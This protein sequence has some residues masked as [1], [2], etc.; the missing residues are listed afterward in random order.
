VLTVDQA[1]AFYDRMGAW[2]DWQRFYEDP[3]LQR[4]LQAAKFQAAHSIIEFG[5]G[6]GRFALQILSEI[7]PAD[8]R[9]LGV[10]L[11]STMAA[12]ARARLCSYSDRAEVRLS[13]GNVTV[14]EPDGRFDRYVSNYVLDLLSREST[15][16]LLSEAHRLLEPGGAMPGQS[17]LWEFSVSEGGL[18][19]LEPHSRRPAGAGWRMPTGRIAGFRLVTGLASRVPRRGFLLR[20]EFRGAGGCARLISDAD[21]RWQFSRIKLATPNSGAGG[22]TRTRTEVALLRILSRLIVAKSSLFYWLYFHQM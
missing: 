16:Q 3:P 21:R 1:R 11:S 13:D 6:T 15:G 12:L 19:R 22:G 2:Q 5:C 7:T 9:Y 14:G 20:P 8:C 18:R 10:D 17:H 4:L